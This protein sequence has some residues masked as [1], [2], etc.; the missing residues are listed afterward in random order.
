MKLSSVGLR[1]NASKSESSPGMSTILSVLVT[2]CGTNMSASSDFGARNG[3]KPCCWP[4]VGTGNGANWSY[5]WSKVDWAWKHKI[6]CRRLNSR[7]GWR[8]F[9]SSFHTASYWV[10]APFD[11]EIWAC[12]LCSLSTGS[13]LFLSVC[14]TTWRLAQQGLLR[15]RMWFSGGSQCEC[16][17]CMF[18][19]TAE[20]CKTMLLLL[21]ALETCIITRHVLFQMRRIISKRANVFLSLSACNNFM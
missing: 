1:L 18:A 5:I 11:V 16:R 4:Q 7:S 2:L 20:W 14:N 8:K 6:V 12:L 9:S 21:L 10:S 13:A 17:S 19:S 15:V 3:V